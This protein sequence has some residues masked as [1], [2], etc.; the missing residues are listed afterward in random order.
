LLALLGEFLR[1]SGDFLLRV[2]PLF[3]GAWLL[4][5]VILVLSFRWVK[6]QMRPRILQADD[7]V[8]A[9]AKT[10]RYRVASGTSA[11]DEERESERNLLT[12]FF[13]FWTNFASAPSLSLLSLAIPL[14]M[15]HRVKAGG[16]V[17]SV[18]ASGELQIISAEAAQKLYFQQIQVWLLPGVCYAG[19]MYLSY[20]LKR[21]FK[22]VRPA[23]NH[24]SFGHKLKDGSFPSGHSLTSFCFWIMVAVSLGL[25]GAAW[26]LVLLLGVLAVTIVALTGLSRIYLGVHFPSDVLGGYVIGLVW[27]ALCFA[28]LYRWL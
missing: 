20:T 3:A 8:R 27:C 13:R 1:L 14:W 6:A 10:L 25:S 16:T 11:T 22:R 5:W 28:A 7:E 21:V 2:L 23:R 9:W 12:W 24:G 15:Y 18:I 4:T 19:S 26:P 17:D